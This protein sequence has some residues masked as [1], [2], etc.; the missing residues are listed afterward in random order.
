M[1]LG[2]PSQPS[3]P[4]KLKADEKKQIAVTAHPSPALG[5]RGC[6]GCDS[7]DSRS[8]AAGLS[9]TTPH[10]E[11]VTAPEVVTPN[12]RQENE[13]RIR[14]LGRSND[15]SGWSDDEVADLVQSLEQAARRQAG[16]GLFV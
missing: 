6:D 10:T 2:W 7:C 3:Q 9:V 11:V 13:Q 14:E 12:N 1:D 16:S 5:E 15:L 8:S 4:K